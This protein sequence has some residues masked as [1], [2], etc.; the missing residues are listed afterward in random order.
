MEA[1]HE[2]VNYFTC[3]HIILVPD[4]GH[5]NTYLVVISLLEGD[6]NNIRPRIGHI[7]T[8][9]A[10]LSVRPQN[11]IMKIKCIRQDLSIIQIYQGQVL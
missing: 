2:F 9:L 10:R 11:C 3:Q 6:R 1:V 4:P 8:S 7:P 5:V